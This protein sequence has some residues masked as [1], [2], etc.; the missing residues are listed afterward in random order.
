MLLVV[1][2]VVALQLEEGRPIPLDGVSSNG[3]DSDYPSCF[4]KPL[5]LEVLL[6]DDRLGFGVGAQEGPSA[7]RSSQQDQPNERKRQPPLPSPP[8]FGEWRTALRA[9][10]VPRRGFRSAARAGQL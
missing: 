6:Q 7:S 5:P 1:L 4:I 8:D 3:V 2:E 9:K 10:P